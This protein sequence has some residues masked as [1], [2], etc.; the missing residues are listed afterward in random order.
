MNLRSLTIILVFAGKGL[1]FEAVKNFSDSLRR[2]SQHGFQRNTRLELAVVS[3][4]ENAVFQ[5]CWDDNIVTWKFAR[6][7]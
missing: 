4:V 6:D 3:Q 2:L 5:H 7:C 1:V